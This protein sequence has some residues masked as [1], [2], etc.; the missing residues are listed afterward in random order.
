LSRQLVEAQ[1]NE[2]QHIAR[3]LHD[4]A[5]QALT[6]LMIDFRLLQQEVGYSPAVTAR[7]E[8]M[9]N[10]T[11][12]ILDNL[13]RLARN[14]RPP[15]LDKLGL[16]PALRQHIEIFGKQHNLEAQF[17][18]VDFDEERLP[19]ELETALYRI[20]QEA[21]NNIA[22]HAHASHVGVGVER[23]G[24]RVVTF[25]ED[26]GTGFDPEEALQQGR[27]GL[28]GMRERIESLGGNLEIES[29]PGLGTTIFVELPYPFNRPASRS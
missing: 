5:G 10:Q 22:R 9:K 12:A 11:V 1:E 8:A 17:E 25:I 6:S 20:V 19:P 29:Q 26:D 14:L 16:V 27:L 3:E 23:R 24:D 21:L 13:H 15:S 7:I 4:E 2:R 28:L 18:T